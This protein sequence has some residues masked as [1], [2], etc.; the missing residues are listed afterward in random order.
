VNL[1]ACGTTGQIQSRAVA[2][3]WGMSVPVGSFTVADHACGL[4]VSTTY[5][6]VITIP[7]FNAITLAPEACFPK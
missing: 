7:G 3:A 5:S 4:K 6:F 2:E 1:T